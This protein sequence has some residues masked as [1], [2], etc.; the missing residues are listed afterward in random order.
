M[1]HSQLLPYSSLFTYVNKSVTGDVWINLSQKP[2]QSADTYVRQIL[3]LL[4][5]GPTNLCLSG[6]TAPPTDVPQ[7]GCQTGASLRSSSGMNWPWFLTKHEILYVQLM[8]MSTPGLSLLP[9]KWRDLNT[10]RKVHLSRLPKLCHQHPAPT[11]VYRMETGVWHK[12]Q[13]ALGFSHCKEA[14]FPCPHPLFL[15]EA[16]LGCPEW[17]KDKTRHPLLRW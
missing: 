11:Q 6:Q 14:L 17:G 2:S 9:T 16:C 3:W 15:M 1:E 4:S 7:P 8:G 13:L 10:S 12:S 5:F